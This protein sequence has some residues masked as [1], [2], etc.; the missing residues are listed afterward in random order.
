MRIVHLNYSDQIGGAATSVMRLHKALLKK[1]INS[2]IFVSEKTTQEKNVISEKSTLHLIF[3][4][5][6]KAFLRNIR[7]LSSSKNISTFS[8]NLIKGIT[9][10]KIKCFK[11]QIIN[12]HWISNEMISLKEISKINIPVVWTLVDMWLFCGGEHYT[13]EKR[14]I[15]GYLKHNRIN[16]EKGFDLNRYIW[17][18]KKKYINKNIKIICISEWLAKEAKKSKLLKNFDIEVINC[19]IDTNLWKPI[20]KI[21]A[22]KIL[23]LNTKKKLILFGATGGISDKRKGFKY[24]LRAL[25]ENKLKKE[26]FD[27]MIFGEQENTGLK[28]KNRKIYFKKGSFYGNDT[29][30]RVFYSAADL[31]VAP[32]ELEAFGQVA[33]EAGACETPCVSFKNTG[34][35]DVI[36]HKK[37]GYLANYKDQN[38]LTNGILWCLKNLKKLKLG[39]KARKNV[40]KKFSNEVISKKY[41]KIYKDLIEQNEQEKK[42]I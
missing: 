6:K 31:L 22:K 17:N 27:I 34:F 37:S 41:L 29:A 33:S 28:F 18:K 25:N 12:I 7:K 21:E 8:M 26:Q 35:E 16:T 42:N 5:L 24:I 13:T 11:P 15:K 14:Y 23:G 30:L 40:I 36:D 10:N 3:N 19:T 2:K 9:F 32:S 38:D 1:K 39:K 20:N 4:L